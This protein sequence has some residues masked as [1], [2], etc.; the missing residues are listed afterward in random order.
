MK[1]KTFKLPLLL[2]A[3]V[4]CAALFG[5]MLPIAVQQIFYSISLSINALLTFFMPM[6]IFCLLFSSLVKMSGYFL[7]LVLLLFP[8]ICVSNFITTMLAYFSGTMVLTKL[9]HLLGAAVVTERLSLVPLWNLKLPKLISNQ[10]AMALAIGMAAVVFVIAKN[11]SG[12]AEKI[13]KHTMRLAGLLNNFVTKILHHIFIP[14]LPLFVFGFLLKLQYDGLLDLIIHHYGLVFVTILTTQLLYVALLYF[15]A[16]GF[17]VHQWLQYL[18]TMLPAWLVGFTTMSSAAA[19][20]LTLNAAIS[21]T[22]DNQMPRLVVPATVNVHLMG[23][24]IAIPIFALAII[25]SIGNSLPDL[26]T[27][28]L[29]AG[30]FIIAKFAVAAVPA[31]GV[32]VM[33]PILEQFLGFNSEMSSL[34]TMLYVLFDCVITSTNVLGNGA[35][36]ILFSKAV[37]WGRQAIGM[38]KV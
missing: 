31:G 35:F 19:M 21:N 4:L 27:Y 23:D 6:L 3:V 14:V 11:R 10:L 20:P 5:E 24:C 38:S 22:K 29:F 1:I 12:S 16:A 7:W 32:I 28:L 8:A 13:T 25:S 18:K 9:S 30:Y 36:V 34:I 15:I 17:S 2:A 26:A 33:V 37:A